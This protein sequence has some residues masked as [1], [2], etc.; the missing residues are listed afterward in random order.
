MTRLRTYLDWNASAPLR[1]EAFKITEL[2]RV[3]RQEGHAWGDM[4]IICRDL[5]AMDECTKALRDRKLPHQARKI[6][7]DFKP[8]AD[9]IVVLTM[10]ACSGLEFAVVAVPGV[11]QMPGAGKDEDEEARLFYLAATRATHKLI[12]TMSGEGAFGWKLW[13]RNQ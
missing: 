4:A 5:V 7:G 8:G 10:D 11:G 2:L 13:R 9:A 1:G 12:V 3:A 6:V